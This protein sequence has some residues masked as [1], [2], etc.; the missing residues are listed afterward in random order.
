MENKELENL[1]DEAQILKDKIYWIDVQI[2]ANKLH[3]KFIE[4]FTLKHKD[5]FVLASMELKKQNNE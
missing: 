2:E 4:D 5:L 3:I 1:I